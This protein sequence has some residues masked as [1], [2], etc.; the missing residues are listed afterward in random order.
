MN[1]PRGKLE[2]SPRTRTKPN[3]SSTVRLSAWDS[4]ETVSSGALVADATPAGGAT[5]MRSAVRSALLGGIGRLWRLRALAKSIYARRLPKEQLQRTALSLEEP[6]RLDSRHYPATPL[7]AVSVAVFRDGKVL[8][9]TRT[10]PPAAGV[11][12]LP[13]G[14]V[15]LGETLEDAALRELD[16]EVG[17]QAQIIGFNRHVERVDRDAQGRVERHFVLVNFV[18]RWVSGEAQT[19]PEAGEVRWVEPHEVSVLP[20]TPALPDVLAQAARLLAGV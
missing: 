16:E 17:V 5:A 3:R 19:G 14:M 6:T 7:L 20:T 9:A 11:W 8:I 10:K 2:I 4:S 13:G 15:E 1:G 18:G 12:S